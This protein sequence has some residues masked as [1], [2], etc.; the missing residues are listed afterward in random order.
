MI[1]TKEHKILVIHGPNMNLLGLRTKGTGREI[2]L[3]KLNRHLRKIAREKGQS[4]TIF[5]TN[6]ES[7]AINR[8]QSQRKKTKGILLFPGPWQQSGHVIK[9]TL[10]LLSIPCIIIS[11]GEKESVLKKIKSIDE[12]DIYIS[13]EKALTELEKLI[14][15]KK[16]YNK[17]QLP[18]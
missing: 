4:L 5:Q 10:E 1:K 6:D 12:D 8:L 17:K 15:R 13:I 9:D 3:D 16:I 2:T 18:I 11:L 14:H 7:R